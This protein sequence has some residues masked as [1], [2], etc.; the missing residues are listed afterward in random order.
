MKGKFDAYVLWPLAQKVQ[1]WIVDWATARDVYGNPIIF[2]VFSCKIQLYLSITSYPN[3]VSICK[4][5]WV[6]ILILGLQVEIDR[7]KTVFT[8]GE[9]VKLFCTVRGYPVPKVEWRK[10]HNPLPTR[11]KFRLVQDNQDYNLILKNV[12][13]NDRGDYSCRWDF[14]LFFIH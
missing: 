8:A 2:E 6:F 12:T 9:D 10:N 11:G 1:N 3:F 14:F 13:Q 5:L 4:A 7:T